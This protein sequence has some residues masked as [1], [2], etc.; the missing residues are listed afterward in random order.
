MER[1]LFALL[2]VA[3]S[4]CSSVS[5]WRFLSLENSAHSRR[6]GPM[7]VRRSNP[8]TPLVR[9]LHGG[10]SKEKEKGGGDRTR[11]MGAGEKVTRRRVQRRREGN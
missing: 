7:D 10:V 11:S 6:G 2:V 8:S 1:V 4:R 5:V 9:R 3:L